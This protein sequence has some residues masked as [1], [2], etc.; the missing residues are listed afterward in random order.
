MMIDRNRVTQQLLALIYEVNET[1]PTSKRLEKS[2]DTVLFGH[3]GQLDS[4][5][6]VNFVVAAEQRIEEEFG[7]PVVLADER[8]MSQSKSPFRTIES[9]AD[10]IC[11]LLGEDVHG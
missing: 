7:R 3:S 1:R 5:G 11:R 10:Y 6:L 8:A 4:L 2:V 9:L